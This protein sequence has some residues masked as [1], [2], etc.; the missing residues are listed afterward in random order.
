M[1]GY[2][3]IISDVIFG[4]V[5]CFKKYI[6]FKINFITSFHQ[7][8]MFL[9]VLGSA[10]SCY[11]CTQLHERNL[12]CGVNPTTVGVETCNGENTHCITY[13]WGGKLVSNSK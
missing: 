8:C 3:L 1:D 6:I 2:I 9:W 10:L 11:N 4:S 12:A 5:L 7:G 13:V